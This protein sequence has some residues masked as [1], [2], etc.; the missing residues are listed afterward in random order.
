VPS[1]CTLEKA[2]RPPT[3]VA[4]KDSAG[5]Q[6]AA[7]GAKKSFGPLLAPVAFGL[8]LWKLPRPDEVCEKGWALNALFA[9]TIFAIALEPM[10]V[11]SIA[12]ISLTIAVATN[13]ITFDEGMAGFKHEVIW[14]VVI[15]FFIA[16][17]FEKTKLATRI[18]LILVKLFGST[19]LGLAYAVIAA[20]LMLGLALPSSAARAAGVLY[21]LVSAMAKEAG[22]AEIGPFLILSTLQA[23]SHGS[24]MWVTAAA[25]NFLSLSC[26]KSVD[27]ES[28]KTA[29]MDWFIPASV[30]AAVG[31]LMC[32]VLATILAPPKRKQTPDLPVM[33]TQKLKA[34]G[35]MSKNEKVMF[36]IML[37]MVAL[38]SA[39][40]IKPVI[41]ALMGLSAMFLFDII[42]WQD[43]TSDKKVWDI[44]TWFAILVAMSAQLQN[45]G[46]IDW[47]ANKVGGNVKAAE[48]P[49]QVSFI[50]LCLT[51]YYS[52]YF[53][54][55]QVAHISAL[56][57]PFAAIMVSAGCPA[58][59]TVLALSYIGNIFS[60][61]TNYSSAQ[62]PVYYSAGYFSL[63]DW[64]KVTFLFSIANMVVWLGVGMLWW[65]IL[66]LTEPDAV[67]AL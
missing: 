62:A 49:W 52:H 33:A 61:L 5:A 67:V 25:T 16:K 30:P 2:M 60:S 66:G 19:T 53:F 42:E 45:L 38:W 37:T 23:N 8:L 54:A 14:L 7:T 9:S 43:C 50:A 27:E 47:F 1:L 39:S 24:A 65:S 6:A 13:T 10:P 46:V 44:F 51:Y 22:D 55:S 64:W 32:P 11:G 35:P 56:F 36:M 59:L 34:M 15:A 58:K 26:A 29:F 57:T 28:S 40:P 18:A 20:E 12:I 17:A 31:C 21:P 41:T 3:V 48:L 63:K 4:V